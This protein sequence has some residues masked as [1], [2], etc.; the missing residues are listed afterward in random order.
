VFSVGQKVVC[1]DASHMV[2]EGLGETRPTA[3]SLYTI[4]HIV[5]RGV[6]GF[7]DHGLLLVEIVNPPLWYASRWDWGGRVRRELHFRARRF[8]PLRTTNIDV[9]TRMLEPTPTCELEEANS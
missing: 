1:V 3:G 5:P 8:R 4:R 6:Y 7:D 2:G 9:F